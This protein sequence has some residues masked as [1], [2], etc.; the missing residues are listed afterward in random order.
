MT[1]FLPLLFLLRRRRLIVINDKRAPVL[2]T[3][4]YLYLVCGNKSAS[5]RLPRCLQGVTVHLLAFLTFLL[6]SNDCPVLSAVFILELA[7]LFNF[8]LRS[9]ICLRELIGNGQAVHWVAAE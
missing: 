7:K 5:V 4:R 1:S 3:L 8:L 6:S 2:G 9:K